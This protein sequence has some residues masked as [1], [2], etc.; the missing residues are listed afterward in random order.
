VQP[1]PQEIVLG[2][3]TLLMRR[4]PK[5]YN[6]MIVGGVLG[7]IAALA[8]TVGFPDQ[9]EYGTAQVF[10]FL[11]LGFVVVGIAL[12]SL[13]AMLLERII[14]RSA[15]TVIADRLGVQAASESPSSEPKSEL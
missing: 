6:F 15:K 2:E 1:E 7:V 12:G 3:A 9:S 14:G 4:S 11:L 5:Y 8:L 13:V 10:G